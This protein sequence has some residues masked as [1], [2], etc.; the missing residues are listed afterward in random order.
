MNYFDFH[1]HNSRCKN[2]IYNLN[3]PDLPA[4]SLFSA[5]IHPLTVSE[6]TDEKWEWLLKV[7]QHPN[8]AAIGECGLDARVSDDVLQKEIFGRQTELANKL[9][10]PII[11]HCVRRFSQLPHFKRKVNVPM[12]VHGFNKKQ[13]VANELRKHDFYLSFGKS[14]LQNVNLQLLLKDLPLEKMFLETDAE[15]GSIDELYRTVSSLKGISEEMLILQIE[16][17]LKAILP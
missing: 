16:K 3:F 13:S 1:H 9:R 11:I 6:S 7:S 17:N 14:L 15:E 12:V 2:G 10:K 5:G 4:D 8:C